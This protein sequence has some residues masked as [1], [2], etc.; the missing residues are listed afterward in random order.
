[1]TK[2]DQFSAPGK[3]DAALKEVDADADGL[4]SFSEFCKLADRD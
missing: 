3:I 4:I 2:T 1:M